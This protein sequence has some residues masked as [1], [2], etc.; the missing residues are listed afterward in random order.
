MKD[1]NTW[2]SVDLPKGKNTVCSKWIYKTNYQENGKIKR[3]KV[4]LV[5]KGY[6]V[7]EGLDYH[8]NCS[9]IVKMVKVWYVIALVVSR[10]WYLQQIDVY[11][12]FL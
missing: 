12:T 11:N 4:I 7:Q 8:E 2:I 5:A 6:S 9:P 3:F 1:N 10:G